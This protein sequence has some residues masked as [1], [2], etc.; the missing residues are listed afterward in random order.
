LA[1]RADLSGKATVQPSVHVDHAAR[2][3]IVTNCT[4]HVNWAAVLRGPASQPSFL[5]GLP[6]L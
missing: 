6:G 1:R 4:H 2:L 5:I 3:K